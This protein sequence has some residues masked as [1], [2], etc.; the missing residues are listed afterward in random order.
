[1]LFSP[2]N[3]CALCPVLINLSGV[4]AYLLIYMISLNIKITLVL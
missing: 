1:M 3:F 4:S 2:I